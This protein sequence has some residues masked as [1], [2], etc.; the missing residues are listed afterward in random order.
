MI[1]NQSI[2]NGQDRR[3]RQNEKQVQTALVHEA[4]CGCH[5]YSPFLCLKVTNEVSVDLLLYESYESEHQAQ[6]RQDGR[7]RQHEKQI[8]TALIYEALAVHG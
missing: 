6:D 1:L 2:Q 4:L 3:E 8:Q 7:E 5:G